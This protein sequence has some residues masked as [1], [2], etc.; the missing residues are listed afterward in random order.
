[1][2]G[3]VKLLNYVA[4]H[5]DAKLRYYASDTVLWID[6]DASYLSEAKSRSTCAGYHFALVKPRDPATPPQPNDAEPMHN[7]APVFIMCNIMKEV[8]S[9]AS[10]AELAGL[11]HNG[12]EETCPIRT[13]LEELG[14]PQPPTPI[15]H[16]TTQPLL[17]VP[18][19]QV[20]CTR[21]SKCANQTSRQ[22]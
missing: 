18:P 4:S 1:M 22:Q 19:G 20:Q 2:N 3:I 16:Q 17:G 9:A 12:K 7:N 14:H 10:E 8:V 5:P 11:F 6:S 21:Y 15:K 13:C